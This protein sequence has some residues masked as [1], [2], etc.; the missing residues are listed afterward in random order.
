M[1]RSLVA[2]GFV[3]VAVAWPHA[4]LRGV[5]ADV[6]PLVAQASA[7]AG[8]RVRLAL[9]VTLPPEFHVQSNV[10]RDP[11]LIP[12]VLT[13]EP[14][15]GMEVVEIVY[16]ASIDL[17]QEGIEQPLAVYPHEF[18]LGVEIALAKTVEIGRA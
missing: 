12:T 11:S 15:A 6:T 7:R 4:Q 16:P 1:R 14:P 2:L 18:A 13:V 10:P 9:V 17:K 8:D 5:K 3:L